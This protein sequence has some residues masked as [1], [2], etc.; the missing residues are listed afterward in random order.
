[1]RPNDRLLQQSYVVDGEPVALP[2][3]DESREHLRQ[4]LISI[5]WEGLKLSSGDPAIPVTVVPAE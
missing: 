4:C 3:L 1:R 5:P 2:T